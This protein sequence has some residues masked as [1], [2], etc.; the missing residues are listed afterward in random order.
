MYSI[1]DNLTSNVMRS[2]YIVTTY[3]NYVMQTISVKFY[4]KLG[5]M[6]SCYCT[7]RL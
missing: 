7:G 2:A 6:A 5:K 1:T 4:K 3:A